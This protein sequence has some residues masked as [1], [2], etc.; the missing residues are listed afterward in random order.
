M[1]AHLYPVAHLSPVD[2]HCVAR[3][4]NGDPRLG[5]DLEARAG[6]SVVA[7]VGPENISLTEALA[8][9]VAVTLSERSV[10]LPHDA[11][12]NFQVKG[13]GG[14][15]GAPEWS[16]AYRGSGR[17]SDPEPDPIGGLRLDKARREF[18]ALT[19]I[20]AVGG[21]VPRALWVWE[22]VGVG[23]SLGQVGAIAL[24]V[25]NLHR[26]SALMDDTD[27]RTLPA[28]VRQ[29]ALDH[30][31]DTLGK[32][33]N[34]MHRRLSLVHGSAYE[35]NMFT[36]GT[37][38]DF[39]FAAPASTSGCEK[40]LVD[41]LWALIECFSGCRLDVSIFTDVYCGRRLSET[42]ECCTERAQLSRVRELA[43]RA[44]ATG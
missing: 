15:K 10:L 8:R 33:L 1:P 18:D 14:S 38:A 5:R 13:A 37:L 40:D 28:T 31:T 44:V 36:D 42:I 2:G 34:L 23:S 30:A 43:V 26:M 19:R 11:R 17:E 3:C 27:A 35:D 12:I 24:A 41:V 9:G 16:I 29:A 25:P 22:F 20:H 39:E 32:T 21:R 6:G 4:E 7:R